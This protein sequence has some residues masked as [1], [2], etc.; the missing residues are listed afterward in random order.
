MPAKGKAKSYG[1]IKKVKVYIPGTNDKYRQI[2]TVC[3][4]MV[5]MV[6]YVY[7]QYSTI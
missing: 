2:L 4:M 1:K 3:S 7:W 5:L 6:L